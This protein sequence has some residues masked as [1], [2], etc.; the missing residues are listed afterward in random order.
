MG[1]ATRCPIYLT[2][3]PHRVVTGL[4][5]IGIAAAFTTSSRSRARSN[6]AVAKRS[7]LHALEALDEKSLGPARELGAGAKLLLLGSPQSP[8]QA[9]LFCAKAGRERRTAIARR[10]QQTSKPVTMGHVHS[11]IC[12]DLLAPIDFAAQFFCQVALKF[13]EYEASSSWPELS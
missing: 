10:V 2:I 5:L 12:R 7:T 3:S 4:T 13:A 11:D 9:G 6:G 1:R 8:A